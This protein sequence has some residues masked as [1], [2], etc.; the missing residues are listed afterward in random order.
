MIVRTFAQLIAISASLILTGFAGPPALADSGDIIFDRSQDAE[1]LDAARVSTT[2]SLQVMGQIYETLLNLDSKGQIVGGLASA[3]Q[4]SRDNKTFTFQIRSNIKC[5]DGSIFDAASAKWNIDRTINPKTGSPNASSYG[6]IT[7]TSVAGNRLTITLAEPYSPLPTFLTSVQSLMMCP[8]T[9]HGANITP[10]GT[11][12]WRFVDWARNDRIILARNPD[13]INYNPLVTDHGPPFEKRLIFRVVPEGS[14]RVAALKT[15][16]ATFVE[17]SLADATDLTK[18]KDY[19]VY[20]GS[21]RTGQLAYLGFTTKIPPLNDVRVRRALGYAIDRR[22]LTDIGFDDLVD[23]STCPVAPRLLGYDPARCATWATSFD[24]A[25]AKALL[26]EAGYGAAHPLNLLFSVS[27]LQG[28]DDAD[29]V[30]QQELRSVG[31]NARIEQRQFAAWVEFM[32]VKNR[33]TTGEPALWT[34]GMSG[35]D[36][37]YLVFLW[38][39]PGYAG[40]GVD[41][42][43]LQQM[44]VDQRRLSGDARAAELLDI[45]RLLLTKAYEIPLFSPG[46]FWLVASKS[47][48]R[49]FKQGYTAMPIFN[50][51][52]LP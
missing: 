20:T 16:Q 3:Y 23:P 7:S 12:P 40:G 35:S 5:Q 24:P 39:P 6:D 48:V 25:K 28:W 19:K 29:V 21:Q 30:I 4:A 1:S 2:L 46:W 34:M 42:P 31:V 11:G 43:V 49:G 14:L 41:D 44:L 36:P 15:G 9:V 38:K 52:Q 17:P 47:D 27:P 45:Q 37:D 10:I 50:D 13:F 32:S 51:V 22:A 18:D 8:S 26:K 33:Q